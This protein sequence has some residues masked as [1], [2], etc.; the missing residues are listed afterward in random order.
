MMDFPVNNNC[1]QRKIL[2]IN[3]KMINKITKKILNKK[4]NRYFPLLNKSNLKPIHYSPI[5]L[6]GIT[7]FTF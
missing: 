1:I 4:L 5:K 3:K 7:I 2:M 6:M